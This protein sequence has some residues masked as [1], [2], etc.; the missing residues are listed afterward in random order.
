MAA[1]QTGIFALG[2]ASHAWLQFDL[3]PGASG[4]QAVALVAD[5]RVDR[6]AQCGQAD[7]RQH[8]HGTPERADAILD[9]RQP[10]R[11]KGRRRRD[12][13]LTRDW[14]APCDGRWLILGSTSHC[15][16]DTPGNRFPIVATRPDQTPV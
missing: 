12:N 8:C 2:T 1:P 15:A 4:A 11:V 5:Q 7:D 13:G 9:P 16:S 6:E 3:V 14:H 10:G